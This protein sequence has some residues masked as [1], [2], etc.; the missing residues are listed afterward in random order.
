MLDKLWRRWN[1]LYNNCLICEASKLQCGLCVPFCCI[2]ISCSI[3]CCAVCVKLQCGCCQAF[4]RTTSLCGRLQ[5]HP[6]TKRLAHTPLRAVALFDAISDLSGVQPGK[7]RGGN[8]NKPIAHYQQM[9]C[10]TLTSLLA[11]SV[12]V[13]SYVHIT[14][15]VSLSVTAG[16]ICAANGRVIYYLEPFATSHKKTSQARHMQNERIRSF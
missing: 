8:F 9:V 13:S 5:F 11:L 1:S 2:C 12:S 15:S 6:G 16:T 10:C 14:C 7:Q 4:K 3:T